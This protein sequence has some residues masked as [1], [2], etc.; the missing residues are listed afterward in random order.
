MAYA[1]TYFRFGSDFKE[2]KEFKDFGDER[3]VKEF[4]E[5]MGRI[6]SD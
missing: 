6:A 4:K 2:F 5:E 3:L 1:D